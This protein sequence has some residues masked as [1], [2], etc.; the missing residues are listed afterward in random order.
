MEHKK[1]AK[2]F[3][4]FLQNV[5]MGTM[6]CILIR[7]KVAT[8][9]GTCEKGVSLFMWRLTQAY[10]QIFLSQQTQLLSMHCMF[11]RVVSS[12]LLH[13]ASSSSQSWRFIFENFSCQGFVCTKTWHCALRNKPST[14]KTN[15]N[16]STGA[17]K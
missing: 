16:A 8:Q 13:C 2:Y 1:Y 9:K 7:W 11:Y 6:Q 17:L 3:V 5:S 4:G 15:R 12:G 10:C 14:Y